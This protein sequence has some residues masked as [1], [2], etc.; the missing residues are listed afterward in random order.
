MTVYSLYTQNGNQAG[1]WIQHRSW[2]NMCA[3]VQTV[4]GHDRGQL[5]GQSPDYDGAPVTVRYF[6]VRSGRE[7]DNAALPLD[8]HDRNYSRIA[9]PYWSRA[10][11]H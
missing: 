1:F 11:C 2:Q 3:R 6:D 5:P 4:A 9:E 8:L 10:V 7:L